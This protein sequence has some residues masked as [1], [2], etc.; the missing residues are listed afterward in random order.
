MSD[1]RVRYNIGSHPNLGSPRD[2]ASP[3][4]IMLRGPGSGENISP[5]SPGKKNKKPDKKGFFYTFL[6]VFT[7]CAADRNA[8][9][10]PKPSPVTF[11]QSSKNQ[12]S[13]PEN[14]I[15]SLEEVVENKNIVQNSS[16]N[17]IHNPKI[18]P[19]SQPGKELTTI[20]IPKTN[21]SEKIENRPL[22][23][24]KT[25]VFY[26]PG[27]KSQHPDYRREAFIDTL[28]QSNVHGVQDAVK[29]FENLKKVSKIMRYSGIEFLNNLIAKGGVN[30]IRIFFSTP[31][32]TDDN[33]MTTSER[34]NLYEEKNAEYNESD[35][36]K[37][38][39]EVQIAKTFIEEDI[40]RAA[41]R[42]FRNASLRNG[43]S[44]KDA[45][46]VLAA[47]ALL[48]EANSYDINKLLHKVYMGS[49][50]LTPKEHTTLQL[51]LP[52]AGV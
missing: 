19:A 3:T 46:G 52:Q 11:A 22:L 36:S 33:K 45:I 4:S 37:T 16:I 24:V 23:G 15:T 1:N 51:L 14:A 17:Y 43:L 18:Y 35:E 28:S 42:S 2:L 41:M 47:S 13:K 34:K 30:T 8:S 12:S 26:T 6:N 9:P 20:E 21:V 29:H 40:N 32:I 7:S 50:Q 49:E 48:N 44:V 31:E 10:N 25:H 39:S 38:H 27:V 5:Q